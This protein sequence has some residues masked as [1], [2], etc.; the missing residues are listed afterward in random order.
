[1]KIVIT[2]DIDAAQLERFNDKRK[3]A[4]LQTKTAFD[5][6]SEKAAGALMHLE[7]IVPGTVAVREQTQLENIIA[8]MA[9]DPSLTYSLERGIRQIDPDDHGN[10]QWEPTNGRTLTLHSGG[11]ATKTIIPCG[12]TIIEPGPGEYTINERPCQQYLG[13]PGPCR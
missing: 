8:E 4:N 3:R 7:E 1:M 5:L 10:A 6:V 9:A 12:R 2:C 13:H 11:G